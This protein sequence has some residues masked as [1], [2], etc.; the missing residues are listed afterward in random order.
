M[1]LKLSADELL[2]AQYI[3]KIKVGAGREVLRLITELPSEQ[4]NQPVFTHITALAL[5]Y[6]GASEKAIEL[7][8]T[9]YADGLWSEE[10]VV[11][12]STA[13]L[14]MSCPEPAETLLTEWEASSGTPLSDSLTVL[15]IEALLVQQDK[16]KAAQATR[17]AKQH[18][19]DK[20]FALRLATARAAVCL[21][22]WAEACQILN[23]PAVGQNNL[24]A[25]AETLRNHGYL[26]ESL[27]LLNYAITVDRTSV[28]TW[29]Q[30]A[31]VMWQLG[32]EDG[33]MGLLADAFEQLGE[34]PALLEAIVRM[35]LDDRSF[36]LAGLWLSRLEAV[37]TQEDVLVRT[38]TAEV[39]LGLGDLQSVENLLESESESDETLDTARVSYY[40]RINRPDDAI[41]YQDRIVLASSR[42]V[43]S[44]LARARLSAGAGR[45]SEVVGLAEEVLE[46]LPNSLAA[47][48]LL[49]AHKSGQVEL[50]HLHRLRHALHRAKMPAR[51]RA[52]ISH[53]LADYHHAIKDHDIAT[54][55][56]VLCNKLS[57]P[58]A[59]SR[60]EGT[61]HRD[62]LDSITAAFDN[63]TRSQP[64]KST[65]GDMQPVFV[66][67]VPRSGTT[68][69]EQI[70]SRHPDITGMGECQHLSLSFTWLMELTAVKAKSNT[71][72]RALAQFEQA[73]LDQL[74][75]RFVSLLRP[76][77]VDQAVTGRHFFVDKMPDNYSLVGWIFKL[78]PEAKVIYA[79]RDP[80]EIA[81]SCWKANFGAI[82]W[83]YRMEDIA[84]RIVQH[85]K[86][87]DVWLKL[88]ENKIF[89]SDYA[90]LVKEPEAQTRKML[91][92][93]GLDWNSACLDHTHAS[94]VVR[95][96]SVNQVR[97]PVYQT[98]LHAW[99]HYEQI[100]SP[101][102]T[103]FEKN[104]LI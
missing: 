5:A 98:S 70:L 74:R 1:P 95:T 81:L 47:S 34:E 33:A 21:E 39:I 20:P 77:T 8:E 87:M 60:Y 100:L 42:S 93:L 30:L 3:A 6:C 83:A 66:V 104:G 71:P 53:A 73:D 52:W 89:V 7:W 64:L 80:R 57:E 28:E 84:E 103:A 99:R 19:A 23:S 29:K 17:L 32:D 16:Q 90:N 40:S 45:G 88:Y 36:E 85:H 69:T 62:W 72:Q 14:A 35:S 26:E 24:P 15:L 46:R 13:Y 50:K 4:G 9:L 68:L 37:L 96:A 102:I 44:L 56:Y 101:A 63:E 55:L 12:L 94:S 51:Q 61:K 76:H 11:E 48:A 91:E 41:A 67:G 10:L 2:Q 27:A 65:S 75:D 31:T 58:A 25:A 43:E 54:E 79:R 22:D 59:E 97:R 18:L 86:T 82:N 92:Y 38:L 49:V 78:F